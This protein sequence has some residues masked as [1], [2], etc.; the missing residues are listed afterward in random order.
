[1]RIY[2]ACRGNAHNGREGMAAGSQR[3]KLRD[4]MSNYKQEAER[5]NRK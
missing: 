5:S 2:A 1:M 3:K 4:H